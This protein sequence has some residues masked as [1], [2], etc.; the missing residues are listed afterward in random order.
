MNKNGF[1]LAQLLYDIV[2]ADCRIKRWQD[3]EQLVVNYCK[4]QDSGAVHN[5]DT[6]PDVS[7][8]NG[9]GIEAKSTTSLTRGINLNSAA[10]DPRTFYAVAHHSGGK[11]RN[12]ALVS[13]QN[14]LC[15]EIEEIKK[16][17]TRLRVLSNQFLRYRTRIM[18]QMQSPFEI[19]GKG[20]FVV[21]KLGNVHRY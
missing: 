4:R 21:D 11:I 12:V 1:D 10:P 9:F 8:S 2:N 13:G 3:L 5:T 18:W 20:N 15:P 17:D 19:W 14:F 6:D 16:T 7:L